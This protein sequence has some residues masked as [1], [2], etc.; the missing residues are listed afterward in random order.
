MAIL[1]KGLFGDGRGDPERPLR[2]PR[3]ELACT[4]SLTLVVP[5]DMAETYKRRE[6][7]AAWGEGMTRHATLMGVG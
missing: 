1:H 5:R 4:P 2:C 7:A 6:A 3:G